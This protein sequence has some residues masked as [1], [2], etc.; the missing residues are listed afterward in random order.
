ML[1]YFI[2]SSF[3]CIV[4]QV[5]KILNANTIN[6]NYFNNWSRYSAIKRSREDSRVYYLKIGES[7][8]RTLINNKTLILISVKLISLITLSNLRN[9]LGEFPF[10]NFRIYLKL[11]CHDQ[12]RVAT[13]HIYFENGRNF[14]KISSIGIFW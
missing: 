5:I 10:Y 3:S 9:N 6:Y 7:Q 12:S 2:I 13:C 11:S 14:Q 1:S 4:R 8:K